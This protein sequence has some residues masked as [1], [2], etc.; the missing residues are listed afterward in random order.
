M[1]RLLCLAALALAPGCSCGTLPT[2][3]DS[4]P[5]TVGDGDGDVVG[6]G[7]GDGD[8]GDG[9]G[10][11]DGDDER[12]LEI[13]PADAVVTATVG[14]DET[15][16]LTAVIVRPDGSRTPADNAFWSSLD[17]SIG[18]VTSAGLFT[19]SRERAGI[20]RV[21]ARAEGIEGVGT[22]EVI[23]NE[24]LQLGGD[25]SDA[26]FDGP[27]SSEPGPTV[28]YPPDAVVIPSNLASIFFQWDKV[29]SRARVT[30]AGPS[31]A[32]VL[33]TDGDAAQAPLDAWRRFLVAH[34][35]QTL[36]VTVEESDGPGT[37][38]RVTAQ[39]LILADADLTSTVYYWAVD[40][41]AI[42][43]ID[44]DSLEPLALDIPYEN[45]PEGGTGSGEVQCRA[46][47]YLSAD[48]Q[49]MAFTYFGGNGPGGVVDT[50]DLSSA[51]IPNR[52][53][54]R[55]NFA[56]LSPDGTFLVSNYQKRLAL[57]SGAT[58][59]VVG[60]LGDLTGVDSAHPA[61][62]PVGD[63]LA[64]AGDL[65]WQDGNPVG[66]EI[67]FER[68]NLYALD[69]TLDPVNPIASAP[70]MLVPG[71]GQ[72]LYYPSF[73][74]SGALVAYTA[75]PY[76]RS[77][78][79]DV[80]QPGDLWL[81]DA[82]AT[83][84]DSGVPR[85]R[86]DS[87]NPGGNSY[88]PTFNPKVEGGYR[89]IAFFS[90]R[91]YGHVLRGVER[92]Q[93]WVAAVDENADLSTGLDPSHPA[94]WLPG[95]SAD[96]DNLSSFFAPKP[97][98]GSGGECSTDSGC[99]FD[100]LCRPVGDVNECVSEEE[101]CQLQGDTCVIDADCCEGLL[102]APTGESGAFECVLPG[103]VCSQEGQLCELDAD[104]CEGAGLCVDDGSGSTRCSNETPGD[105]SAFGEACATRPCCEGQ[106]ICLDD[107]CTSVGG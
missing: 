22:V 76:S 48:G 79:D 90:R 10:D 24:T 95:Q 45:V 3:P 57:R 47:H 42:V 35:G 12:T 39:S 56:A 43:R 49:S 96:T 40:Q 27:V 107:I 84:G 62:S 32:L 28:L 69:L 59:D 78:R 25:V 103:E 54:R 83:P 33:L 99:C 6:D 60:G 38:R 72:A 67:D 104:C 15:L 19:P 89:W 87:A 26:D 30:I 36:D 55:W 53:N 17:P 7:D 13:E 46:C 66:W 88:F 5:T 1:G 65:T 85:V 100:L 58:G 68:S 61:F 14:G 86:L 77:R 97:C 18:S 92:P 11:G 51:V 34:V 73:S 4:G 82:T 71:E 81:A 74:P 2:A 50:A 75:G 21:R 91:D 93:V 106:G 20:A 52:D 9:D 8:A 80:N 105:C 94:F 16:Q 102:C 29:R 64:F 101:A 37:E 23:L 70:T 31:G 63:R 98:A 44:A 41:G